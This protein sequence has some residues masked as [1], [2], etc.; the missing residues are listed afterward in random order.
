MPHSTATNVHT[1]DGE[2]STRLPELEPHW[3]AAGKSSFEFSFSVTTPHSED[4]WGVG[5]W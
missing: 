1:P 5:D 2:L 4:V 3:E